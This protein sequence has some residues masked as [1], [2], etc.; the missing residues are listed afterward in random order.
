MR[1]QTLGHYKLESQ[2]GAG[3][4]GVVYLATDTRL[5][6]QVAIK[7]LHESSLKDPERRARFEREARVLASLNHPNIAA[8]HGLEAAGEV[9]FLVLEYV[10]GD[11]LSQR[12][13]KAPL[14]LREA[15]DLG[16]QVADALDAA[17]EAGVIHRDL[18]PANLKITPEGKAKVLDFGLAKALEAEWPGAADGETETNL[19]RAGVVMGTV[20]YMSPEQAS[21]RPVDRRT[22]IWA[23][24]CVMYEALSGK[25]TFP[26]DTVAKILVGILD[27]EPEWGA[28]PANAPENV[29]CVRRCLTK[30]PRSR[31]RDIGD[32]RLELEET[33]S[34]RVTAPMSVV[35]RRGPGRR[36]LARVAA[37]LLMGAAGVGIWA[38]QSAR[39]AA[40]PRVARLSFDLP[41]G[42]P[43][44]PVWAATD[45]AFSPDSKTLVYP[46]NF[47]PPNVPHARR[48][49]E[50][51]GKPLPDA[52]GL[53]S[54]EPPL[55]TRQPLAPDARLH[56]T[57]ARQVSPQRWGAG[58]GRPLRH[59][60]PRRLGHGRPYL[61]DELVDRRGH[62]DSGERRQERTGNRTR[63]RKARAHSPLCEAVAGR[64]GADVYC[65]LGRH[66]FLRRCAD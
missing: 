8:I 40:P 64:K 41:Q 4:M 63:S 39:P 21:G 38:W 14:P 62:Q 42:S 47:P 48:I 28:L 16:R 43:I 3:G 6:R 13:A 1:E 18:K 49:D 35:K 50:L 59:A 37:G 32:A 54:G 60:L 5:G 9:M 36:V 61:L 46:V 20:P 33:L 12:L 66:R 56:Q 19:S 51:D 24:G 45:L 15:L 34:G 10:P 11:T 58:P 22:D 17:H 25:R 55:F 7:L 57:S 29:T 44:V 31:L 26:G 27:R 52:K 53:V 23:F 30:D 2:L 65:G